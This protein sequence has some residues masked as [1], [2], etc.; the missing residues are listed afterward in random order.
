MNLDKA[1]LNS[2]ASDMAKEIYTAQVKEE[3]K[4]FLAMDNYS[5][6]RLT[7]NMAK[8]V[9]ACIDISDIFVKELYKKYGN[10]N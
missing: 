9:S 6:E 4:K 7:N 8:L 10:D 5:P 3:I 1:N 2:L